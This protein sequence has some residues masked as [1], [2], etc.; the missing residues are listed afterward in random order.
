MQHRIPP[1]QQAVDV[2]LGSTNPWGQDIAYN[3]EHVFI[4][5]G[6]EVRK[7]PIKMNNQTIWVDCVSELMIPDQKKTS[8]P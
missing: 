1:P 7:M 4:E 5:N 8:I 2:S 6:R 3:V